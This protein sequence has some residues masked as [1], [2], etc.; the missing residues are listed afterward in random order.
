MSGIGLGGSNRCCTKW[1]VGID[2]G[3]GLFVVAAA[4]V[5]FRGL[6]VPLVIVL[7][8]AHLPS[9]LTAMAYG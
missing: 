5:A 2:C 3:A 9:L 1:T 8:T 6:A 4:Q 7:V